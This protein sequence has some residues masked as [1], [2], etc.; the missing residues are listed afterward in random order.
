MFIGLTLVNKNNRTKQNFGELNLHDLDDIVYT[1][2]Y[3]IFEQY[4]KK[5]LN[6][7]LMK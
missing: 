2:W 6:P 5:C 7:K 1:D 4:R 3:Q